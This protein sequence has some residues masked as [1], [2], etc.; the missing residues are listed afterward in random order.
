[1]KKLVT[2][3]AVIAFGFGANAQ[4]YKPTKGTVTTEVG[5]AGGLGETSVGLNEGIAKFRYFLKDNIALRLGLGFSSSNTES[6]SVAIAPA[7]V[8]T[9]TITKL[10]NRNF[11]LGAE[12]H[13]NGSD[14]LST[15]IGADLLI[16][17]NGASRTETDSDGPFYNISGANGL[18][19]GSNRAGS[20]FG[21]RLVTGAD[22]YIAKK[23][24]LGVEV[25]LEYL[26]GTAD[27]VSTSI[28]LTPTGPTTE[29]NVASEGK[30]SGTNTNI[31]G[32]IKI[33]YQF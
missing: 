28:K 14:R 23:L 18:V 5:V 7:T 3:L 11:S 20:I 21:I 19:A 16:G 9:T 12:K 27:A 32:G 1:M 15:F 6:T 26:S 22:Y 17:F 8:T 31:V 30:I 33:G 29:T 25:G 24:Y 4:E 13:F 10:S 2:L